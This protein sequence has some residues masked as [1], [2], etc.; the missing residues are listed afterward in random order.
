[1]NRQY[2]LLWFAVVALVATVLPPDA[3]AY[4]FWRQ[5]NGR[6]DWETAGF[7]DLND[8]A[9]AVPAAAAL[10]DKFV[11]DWN[12]SGSLHRTRYRLVLTYY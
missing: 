7:Y 3:A 1:M 4:N 12:I 9:W 11:F 10:T 2:R 8:E 6:Q 5:Y